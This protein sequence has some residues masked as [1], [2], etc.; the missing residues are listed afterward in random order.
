MEYRTLWADNETSR[1]VSVHA[2]IQRDAVTG[3]PL[4]VVGVCRDITNEKEAVVRQ[5]TFLKEMLFGLTEGRLRLCD[6]AADLPASL[7]TACPSVELTPP[8]VRVLRKQVLAMSEQMRFDKERV[9]DLETAVGEAGMNAI[10]HAHG[11][12]GTV[13]ADAEKGT[14]QVWVRDEGNGIAEHLIHRAVERGWTTGGFGQGMFLMHRTCDRVYLL[15]G[16]S[17]TTVVLE[18]DRAAPA[19]AWLRNDH[20]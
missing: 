16:V 14:L 13:C 17:G 5:R 11:G 9:Q 3:K 19:P 4:R 1:W 10:R 15:T 12:V 7:S 20:G 2:A 6:A 8:T 18:Q